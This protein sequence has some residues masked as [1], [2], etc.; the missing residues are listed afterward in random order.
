MLI[1][2]IELI[3]NYD[4]GE[5]HHLLAGNNANMNRIIAFTNT[6]KTRLRNGESL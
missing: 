2:S 4:I 6:S 3:A 1:C 5:M